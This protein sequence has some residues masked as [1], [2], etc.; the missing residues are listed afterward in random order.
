MEHVTEEEEENEEENEEEEEDLR[1]LSCLCSSISDASKSVS[2]RLQSQ[3]FDF[4]SV[5]RHTLI[6]RRIKCVSD[7]QGR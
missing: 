4:D 6:N 3:R 7:R 5:A 1:F 2:F